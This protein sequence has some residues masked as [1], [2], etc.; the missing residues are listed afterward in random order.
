MNTKN[1]EKNEYYDNIE[2]YFDSI[3]MEKINNCPC[4]IGYVNL[5][6]QILNEEKISNKKKKSKK[7]NKKKNEFKKN[8]LIILL[9]VLICVYLKYLKNNNFSLKNFLT[10][11]LSYI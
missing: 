2:K 7:N 1:P 6:K 8:I 11:I 3:N 5:D 4:D 10:Q 9:V